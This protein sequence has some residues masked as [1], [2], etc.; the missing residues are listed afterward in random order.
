MTRPDK[1]GGY[2]WLCSACFTLCLT[3]LIEGKVWCANDKCP[4]YME[5]FH[6]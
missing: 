1:V 2:R 5:K 3:S 4:Q 6:Q